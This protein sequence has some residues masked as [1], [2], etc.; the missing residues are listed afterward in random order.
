MDNHDR[1]D[2]ANTS[3]QAIH[4]RTIDDGSTNPNDPPLVGQTRRSQKRLF[5]ILTCVIV[6]GAIAYAAFYFTS[7]NNTGNTSTKNRGVPSASSPL[8]KPSGKTNSSQ[9]SNYYV[10]PAPLLQ[11]GRSEKGVAIGYVVGR[12]QISI[13]SNLFDPEVYADSLNYQTAVFYDNQVSGI[14]Q[15][16]DLNLATNTTTQLTD[17]TLSANQPVFSSIDQELAYAQNECSVAIMSIASGT[18]TVIQNGSK[19]TTCYK[20]TA[21][22]PDGHYLA[23][24][25]NTEI[26]SPTL[27]LIGFSKL[28]IYN[29]NTKSST[30]ISAPTGFNSVGGYNDVYWQDSTHI[31]ADYVDYGQMA[32]ILN[33]QLV[34]VDVS[35]QQTTNLPTVQNLDY[36]SVQLA[37]NN[38]YA[39]ST[40]PDEIVTGI[41][42]GSALQPLAGSA[43]A[44]SFLLQT[45][46]SGSMV[47]GIYDLAGQAGTQGSWTLNRLIPVSGQRTQLYNIKGI[48]A[49]MLGFG[50][51]YDN[52]IYMD[53]MSGE[54]EIHQY[55]IS[56]NSDQTLITNLPLV[57][58]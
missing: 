23:Y 4:N 58:D 29:V 50:K 45:D 18:P 28:Y 34:L 6:A 57:Q 24:V 17:G 32:T 5:I 30:P 33:Q 36:S 52:I 14:D 3:D 27:G 48:S 22:S 38:M 39:I 42:T 11:N 16:F 20:P 40:Q 37:G 13:K 31:A 19:S 25:G 2:N 12:K 41:D 26:S 44:G 8:H 49:Y 1:L 7:T 53:V 21:W 51:S 15:V 9:L 55:T 43:D 47:N 10:P 56:T 46:P 54:D 35:N